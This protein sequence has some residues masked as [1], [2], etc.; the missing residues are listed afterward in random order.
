MWRQLAVGTLGLAALAGTTGCPVQ[1]PTGGSITCDGSAG[2]LV[3][4]PSVDVVEKPVTYSL[5]GP[6][7]EV[8]CVDG[9]GSGITGARL[10]ALSV[11]FPSLSCLVTPGATATGTATVRW[12][13]GSLSEGTATAVLDGAYTGE[14]T[15]AVT[16]GRFEGWSGTTWFAATPLVGSCFE[17][18]ISRESATIG[19]LTLRP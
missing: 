4:T 16:S 2:E 1:P 3:L 18:G 9:S 13:D 15:L 8:G 7:T 10:D 19:P 6:S 5:D 17:D 12:S 14:L 11:T